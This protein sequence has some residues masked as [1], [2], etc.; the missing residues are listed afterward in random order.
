MIVT[1]NM[2]APRQLGTKSLHAPR[3]PDNAL[4]HLHSEGKSMCKI[5]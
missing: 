3:A 5:F 4:Y 1:K 2:A